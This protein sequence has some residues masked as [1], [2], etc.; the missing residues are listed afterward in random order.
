[1]PVIP[2]LSIVVRES[3]WDPYLALVVICFESFSWSIPWFFTFL[4]LLG[5]LKITGQLFCKVLQSVFVLIRFKSHIFGRNTTEVLPCSSHSILSGG[6]WIWFAPSLI[7]FTSIT[8]QAL[9]VWSYSFIS[10]GISNYQYKHVVSHFIQW[11][12]I[13]S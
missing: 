8:C 5:F 7:I 13:Y 10:F 1:M 3:R 11:I 6:A 9:P 4:T 12:S 2:V